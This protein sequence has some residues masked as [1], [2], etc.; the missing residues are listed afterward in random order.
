M[1]I[2]FLKKNIPA[3]DV[4]DPSCVFFSFFVAIV[5]LYGGS[6]M[7]IFHSICLTFPS[8]LALQDSMGGSIDWRVHQKAGEDYELACSQL[9][10]LVPG[11]ALITKG[12]LLPAKHVIHVL[13]P[14]WLHFAVSSLIIPSQQ[15]S[16]NL[17]KK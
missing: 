2:P 4:T 8:L 5:A 16:I 17:P 14:V 13:S 11:H 6:S 15:Y 9:P 12:F 1:L 10:N 7:L 3:I